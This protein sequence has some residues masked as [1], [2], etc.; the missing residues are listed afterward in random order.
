[1]TKSS[2]K[3][4]NKV[5]GRDRVRHGVLGVGR[6]A[7]TEGP[8]K[9][10][11]AEASAGQLSPEAKVGVFGGKRRKLGENEGKTGEKRGISGSFPGFLFF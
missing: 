8:K 10:A 3:N 9:S 7:G 4:D 5:M 11:C 1:M 2:R 6:E